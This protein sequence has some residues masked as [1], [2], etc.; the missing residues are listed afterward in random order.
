MFLMEC[1]QDG[2]D[3]KQG[4]GMNN[5]AI[6]KRCKWCSV[7]EDSSIHDSAM[8]SQPSHRPKMRKRD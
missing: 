2:K 6:L 5:F 7:P 4:L 8:P 1:G 3:D